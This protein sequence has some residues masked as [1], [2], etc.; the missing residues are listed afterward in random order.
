MS[1]NTKLNKRLSESE[2]TYLCLLIGKDE[3]FPTFKF[4]LMKKLKELSD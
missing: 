1:K 3:A 4:N 2:F